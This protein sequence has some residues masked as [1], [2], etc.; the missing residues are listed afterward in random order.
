MAGQVR[1]QSTLLSLLPFF[2][3]ISNSHRLIRCWFSVVWGVCLVREALP[4]SLPPQVGGIQQGADNER[5]EVKHFFNQLY[6]MIPSLPS[7][8]LPSVSKFLV[9]ICFVLLALWRRGS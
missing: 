6:S 3:L 1:E 2:Y 4:P 8:L 9:R 5:K 7:S